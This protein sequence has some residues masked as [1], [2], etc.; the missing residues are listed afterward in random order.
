M[1]IKNTLFLIFA[2][3]FLK[4]IRRGQW[5]LVIGGV[6][7][8]IGLYFL[9][10]INLNSAAFTFL[11]NRFLRNGGLLGIV[12]NRETSH[13]DIGYSSFLSSNLIT[14]LIGYGRGADSA[15][16]YMSGSSSYKC[17]VYNYGYFGFGL[18][19]VNLLYLVKIYFHKIWNYW[20][21]ITLIILFA[22]SIYQ[23][24]SVYS[25]YYFLIL[26]GG[27][28]YLMNFRYVNNEIVRYQNAGN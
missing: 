11:Q 3:F 24:P 8:F 27:C 5:K 14:K 28:S 25:P 20:P 4:W 17:L 10:N 15:N 13:F 18:M 16:I 22:I 12:N 23:R 2:Y 19:M 7:F 9:L 26:L 1:C 21:Q 6:C